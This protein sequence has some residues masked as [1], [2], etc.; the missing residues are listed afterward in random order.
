MC[1]GHVDCNRI[2]MRARTRFPLCIAPLACSPSSH[3]FDACAKSRVSSVASPF[4]CSHFGVASPT[5]LSFTP[6][7]ISLLLRLRAL[8]LIAGTALLS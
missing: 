7:H 6:I 3:L 2:A 1:S 4:A 8:W 5:S